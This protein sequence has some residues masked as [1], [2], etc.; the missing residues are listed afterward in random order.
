MIEYQLLCH[1]FVNVMHTTPHWCIIY[2]RH[3]ITN[4]WDIQTNTQV[5]IL[6]FVSEMLFQGHAHAGLN[7]EELCMMPL[8][9]ISVDR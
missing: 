1:Y 3:I 9:L 7:D 2:V 5:T 4:I 8:H 6:W